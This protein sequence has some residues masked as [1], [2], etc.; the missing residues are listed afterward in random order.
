M[1][2]PCTKCVGLG[3]I[4]TGSKPHDLSTGLKITCPD[5]HGTGSIVE[6]MDEAVDK[7]GDPKVQGPDQPEATGGNSGEPSP[8]GPN[9]GDS[10]E[11]DDGSVGVLGKDDKGDWVCVPKP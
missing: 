10:C 9:I 1:S 6:S 7:S 4:S 11:M 8:V 5:C 2:I 3:L